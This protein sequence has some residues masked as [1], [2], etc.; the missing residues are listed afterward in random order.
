MRCRVTPK[1]LAGVASGVPRCP[2]RLGAPEGGVAVLAKTGI[3]VAQ[4][5]LLDDG[6]FVPSR[7][8]AAHVHAALPGSFVAAAPYVHAGEGRLPR[9][10]ALVWQV[11]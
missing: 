1:T 2:P 5:P 3:A 11:V 4:A 10:L 8:V 6:I 7:V 9:N